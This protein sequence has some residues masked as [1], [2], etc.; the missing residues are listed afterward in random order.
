MHSGNNEATFQVNIVVKHS[1][2]K[3]KRKGAKHFAYAVHGMEIPIK[4]TFQEYRKRFGIESSYK[5]MNAGRAN[6]IQ[7]TR[8]KIALFGFGIPVNKYLDLHTMD[9]SIHQKTRRPKTHIMAIQN[10]AKTNHQENRRYK[11][12]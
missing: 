12:I 5:L 2:G 10:N 3:Y 11:W 8:F 6:Y 7:K 1:K 4:K 9:L